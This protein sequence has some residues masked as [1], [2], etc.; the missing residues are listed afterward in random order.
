MS[1]SA[2]RVQVYL[3]SANLT[4]NARILDREGSPFLVLAAPPPVR[5]KLRVVEADGRERGF[6]VLH[7]VEVAEGD[8]LAGVSGRW[9]DLAA[10]RAVGSEHLDPD[11][12]AVAAAQSGDFGASA[13]GSGPIVVGSGESGTWRSAESS[14]T[15]RREPS[16]SFAPP[17]EGSGPR[18]AAAHEG[19]G[20]REAGA[21]GAPAPVLHDAE[22][23]APMDVREDGEGATERGDDAEAGEGATPAGSGE[24]GGRGKKRKGRS[25][26]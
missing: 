2:E 12:D 11:P 4:E 3:R 25:R 21:V 19:S 16:G 14:G 5:A 7:V 22:E 6:E 1:E 20:P 18:E 15:Y 9:I 26:G 24:D 13:S 23:S 10:A 17:R 8:K